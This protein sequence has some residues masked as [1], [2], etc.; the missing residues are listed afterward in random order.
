MTGETA[1]HRIALARPAT[2][3]L[4]GGMLLALAIAAVPLSRLAHQSLNASNGSV[5][6]WIDAAY[7]AV[8]LTVAWR[9]PGNPLG[10]IFLTP[11]VHVVM[12]AAQKL[13]RSRLVE[14]SG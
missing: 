11:A 13:T 9:K 6:V 4:L 8:G 10:W 5:P 3:W 14:K 1:H 12:L 7:G 2:A